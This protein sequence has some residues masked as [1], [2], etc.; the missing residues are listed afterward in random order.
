MQ[1]NQLPNQQPKWRRLPEDDQ[2][3]YMHDELCEGQL[4]WR[5]FYL[6]FQR[7]QL[8]IDP[9]LTSSLLSHVAETLSQL[10]Q[11]R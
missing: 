7:R 2:P 11:D 4:L 3:G 5:E 10:P 8:V 1:Q 9:A 6:E